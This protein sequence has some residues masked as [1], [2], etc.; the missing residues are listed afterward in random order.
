M[1]RY[2]AMPGASSAA[3]ASARPAGR[4]AGSPAP[5][6]ARSAAGDRSIER[7]SWPSSKA[8]AKLAAMED[9]AVPVLQ[10]RQQ[11]AAFQLGRDRVPVDV[12][13]VGIQRAHAVLKHVAPPAIGRR[14]ESHVIG[15]EVEDQTHPALPQR[16]GERSE[17]LIAAE[18]GIERRRDRRC[19][20]RARC[21]APPAAAAMHSRSVTPSASR[22]G[23]SRR[24]IRETETGCRIAVC[25]NFTGRWTLSA[26]RQR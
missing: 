26:C 7:E 10:N 20:S 17:F 22:Y 16:R 3:I 6:A 25:R 8:D 14:V 15:D 19:R 9:V 13:V 24:G 12:E 23:T 21:R 18:L 2:S 5:N 1:S 4:R 11:Q